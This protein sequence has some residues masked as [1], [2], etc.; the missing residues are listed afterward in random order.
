MI[1]ASKLSQKIIRQSIKFAKLMIKR[2]KNTSSK[3][4]KLFYN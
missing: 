2:L 4:N 3:K 1:Q